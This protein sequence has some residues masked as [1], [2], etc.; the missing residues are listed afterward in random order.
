MSLKYLYNKLESMDL[1]EQYCYIQNIFRNFQIVPK[2]DLIDNFQNT[3][4]KETLNKNPLGY[5]L[6]HLN[7]VQ[8]D[9]L[10]PK[11]LRELVGKDTFS[12]QD[13][14]ILDIIYSAVDAIKNKDTYFYFPYKVSAPEM[15]EVFQKGVA[16][17]SEWSFLKLNPYKLI[18]A[19]FRHLY[20]FFNTNQKIDPETN[21]SHLAHAECNKR[22][23]ELIL[24]RKLTNE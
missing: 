19:L 1:E 5:L 22:M 3:P 21:V 23:I 17:Y 16:K 20:K 24:E 7:P 14:I 18:P 9:E 4:G 8:I 13:R 11:Y 15:F 12:T 2:Y 6:M 10:L